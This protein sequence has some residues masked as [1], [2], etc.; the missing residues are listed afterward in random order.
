MALGLTSPAD[1]QA[2]E[3]FC[4]ILFLVSQM[5]EGCF[6]GKGKECL[7]GFGRVLA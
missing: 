4:F 1:A 6:G 5:F 7:K 3:G 2:L